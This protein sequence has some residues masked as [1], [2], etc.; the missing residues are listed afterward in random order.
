MLRSFLWF[1]TL[2]LLV[3]LGRSAAAFDWNDMPV[4]PAAGS[5]DFAMLVLHIDSS[6]TARLSFSWVSV[7][8]I[9]KLSDV[10]EVLQDCLGGST[11]I[12]TSV[13][14]PVRL[15]SVQNRGA[16]ERHGLVVHGGMELS[17]LMK[18]LR[19][20]GLTRLSLSVH[21]PHA[22]FY[23][24]TPHQDDT[25][26]LKE[27]RR[28]LERTR[29]RI[30]RRS[31]L[32]IPKGFFPDMIQY[33]F[34]VE[35]LLPRFELQF[36]YGRETLLPLGSLLLLILL[37]PIGTLWLRRRALR[38]SAQDPAA[39]CFSFDRSVSWIYLIALF[40]WIVAVSCFHVDERLMEIFQFLRG[41]P[42]LEAYPNAFG[43][44]PIGLILVPNA[45]VCL[46]CLSLSYPVFKR[47]RGVEWTR[48]QMIV[49]AFWRQ[50]SI[51][52]PALFGCCALGAFAARDFRLVVLWCIAAYVSRVLG[53]RLRTSSTG[54]RPVPVDVG[55]LRDRIFELAKKAGVAIRQVYLV[56]SGQDRVA[57][58]AAVV[59]N[60]VVLYDYLVRSLSRREVDAVIAHELAHLRF[61]HPGKGGRFAA[62]VVFLFAVFLF[63]SDVSPIWF[64][65]ALA[66]RPWLADALDFAKDSRLLVWAIFL[67]L[68]VVALSFR[69]RGW[70]FLADRKAADL[71]GDTAAMI[72]A[73]VK[74]AR[75][76]LVPMEWGK[77]QGRL[78]THP[79]NSRRLQSLAEH[80]GL[81][82][83]G[84][85]EL[86]KLPDDGS[87][88]YEVP[89]P[90]AA[91][92][93]IFSPG[94]KQRRVFIISWLRLLT[95]TLPPAVVALA[96]QELDLREPVRPLVLAGGFLATCLVFAWGNGR[97]SVRGEPG[98][99]RRFREKQEHEQL[100]PAEMGALC[101]A[102]SPGSTI[103]LYENSYDWDMGCLYLTSGL[104]CYVGEQTRFVLR[105][106]QIVAIRLQSGPPRWTRSR[107]VHVTW[108]DAEQG[109]ERVFILRPFGV[110]SLRQLDREV[111]Q[112]HEQLQAWLQDP[113]QFP[114]PSKPLL[115]LTTPRLGEVTGTAL[116]EANLSKRL[117]NSLA[118]IG[119]VAVGVSLLF[120]PFSDRQG[121][122]RGWYVVGT[123]M[124]IWFLFFLPT[125]W[126]GQRRRANTA[127]AQG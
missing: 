13:G 48:R 61:R 11:E 87:G 110:R 38:T 42:Y 34:S 49:Q 45:F 74:L 91:E 51:V 71:T 89:L 41:R 22:G 69:R 15:L 94:Y 20:R 112:L 32:A 6:A 95:L 28:E 113:A 101:I 62:G 98:L 99:C 115:Q 116:H 66:R 1:C 37:P 106:E 65:T 78:L 114:A 52:L 125:W 24:S 27:E 5:Q 18:L 83:Q 56:P 73:L 29:R 2:T 80:G 57:N 31:G 92:E 50:V 117:L 21:H 67:A 97:L 47:L 120:G 88:T 3:L 19:S 84:L 70:E 53:A 111:M 12:L 64:A 58:A 118:L 75:L 9:P 63:L 104:L 25:T 90:G 59:G 102:F 16:F 60:K 121:F 79:S 14:A 54:G 127:A 82:R 23:A 35:E 107:R 103:K 72:T 43:V 109:R 123:S 8:P 68:L 96:V 100:Q 55:P 85:E 26:D 86:V 7:K 126:H 119:V 44:W 76:N 40:G 30:L 10:Q 46:W 108:R 93:R 4:H 105:P 77:W 39:A 81:S 36:G 17:P 33:D 122:F 124:L